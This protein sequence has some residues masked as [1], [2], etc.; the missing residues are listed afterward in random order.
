MAR[1]LMDDTYYTATRGAKI[2]I[3]WT[4]PEVYANFACT[5]EA[6]ALPDY[7][8]DIDSWLIAYVIYRRLSF[9]RSTPPIVMYGAMVWCCLRSGQSG[10][11]HSHNLQTVK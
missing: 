8:C 6:L 11:S 2:P 10:R 1:D 3:K 4:A 7:I 5:K 9:T